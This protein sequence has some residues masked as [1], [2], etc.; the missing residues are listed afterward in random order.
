L[1]EWITQ[2]SVSGKTHRF[3]A[4]RNPSKAER[5]GAIVFLDGK[6]TRLSCT[7]N[8]GGYT[9]EIAG[10]GTETVGEGEEIQW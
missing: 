6:G 10:G 7:V 2:V 1:P 3:K 8:Q 5:S 4:V 9:T